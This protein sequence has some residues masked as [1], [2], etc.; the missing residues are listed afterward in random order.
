MS[1]VIFQSNQFKLSAGVKGAL[2]SGVNF[3]QV[4][5]TILSTS[6]N[7][8]YGA[9]PVKLVNTSNKVI[10]VEKATLTDIVFGFIVFNT[11]KNL[12]V[13]KDVVDVALTG[14]IMWMECGANINAGV[15]VETVATGDKI[16]TSAG[17]NTVVGTALFSGVNGDLI[18]V[19]IKCL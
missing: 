9:T 1:G 3:Q 2:Y 16:I 6:V 11:T 8:F 13:A 12:R 7:N 10:T 4:A 18:P 15:A 14:A 5:A 19:L 17:T